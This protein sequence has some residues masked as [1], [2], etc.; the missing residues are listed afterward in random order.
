MEL[1]EEQ[2]HDTLIKNNDIPEAQEATT[3]AVNANIDQPSNV[4]TEEAPHLPD[5]PT[6]V[7]EVTEEEM[8][9]AITEEDED[10]DDAE[11]ELPTILPPIATPLPILPPT[12]TPLPTPLICQRPQ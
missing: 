12:A 9:E 8:L 5:V 6:G 1:E 7:D 3:A 2:V 11:P 4:I 10:E